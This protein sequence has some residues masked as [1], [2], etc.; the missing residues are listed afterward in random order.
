MLRSDVEDEEEVE[1][2][3]AQAAASS[4]FLASLTSEDLAFMA[5]NLSVSEFDV[6]DVIMQQGEMATWVGIVLS[7]SLV[8]Y[9]NG[10]QV[11]QMRTGC[12]VG[13]IAFFAG[14]TRLADV[15]AAEKGYL[16]SVMVSNLGSFFAEAPRTAYKL[17]RILGSSSIF[18]ITHNAALHAPLAFDLAPQEAASDV[19]AWKEDRF[20]ETLL[21][22]G[23]DAEDGHYLVSLMQ[24][25]RFVAGEQLLDA[26][27]VN[28]C[29]CFVVSGSVEVV[30][31]WTGKR[32]EVGQKDK[33][34]YDVEFFEPGALPSTIVGREDGIIGSLPY[35]V[36]ESL[37]QQKPQLALQAM[38]MVGSSALDAC[39]E[40]ARATAPSAQRKPSMTAAPENA[41]KTRRI[42]TQASLAKPSSLEVFYRNK[43]AKHSSSS[44]SKEAQSK[45]AEVA[46]E[47]NR[48][49]KS[50]RLA[51]K[52][53][54]SDLRRVEEQFA[55]SKM[56]NVEMRNAIKNLKLDVK[57]AKEEAKISSSSRG[58]K[59]SINKKSLKAAADEAMRRGSLD[60]QLGD[61]DP[62]AAAED[63]RKLEAA[64]SM[65]KELRAQNEA[66]AQ[67]VAASVTEKEKLQE[68]LDYARSEIL[69]IMQAAEDEMASLTESHENERTRLQELLELSR[70]DA[71]GQAKVSQTARR[72]LANAE[73]RAKMNAELLGEEL[74]RAEG[75]V[76]RRNHTIATQQLAA[77]G[78]GIVYVSRLYP[79]KKEIRRLGEKVAQ[80]QQQLLVIPWKVKTLEGKVAKAEAALAA[81]KQ[82][83]ASAEAERDD[84]V[85]ACDRVEAALTAKQKEFD[86]VSKRAEELE[87]WS[88]HLV[89]EL[90]KA[91]VQVR[92]LGVQLAKA[93]KHETQAHRQ[94]H[95]WA[96]RADFAADE[97]AKMAV[98]VV[99]LEHSFGALLPPTAKISKTGSRSPRPLG[100][101]MSPGRA[102]MRDGS[103][104][105]LSLRA[106]MSTPAL[107][108][109]W[110]ATRIWRPPAT[111]SASA[112]PSRPQSR[113]WTPSRTTRPTLSES[114]ELVRLGE[115]HRSG[116]RKD[117]A[118]SQAE[119]AALPMLSPTGDSGLPAANPSRHSPAVLP[120]VGA[121]WGR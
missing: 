101:D 92:H 70:K 104:S 15:R 119:V 85:S 59:S 5:Q 41:S 86:V 84:A 12:V 64:T 99:T 111:P 93:R 37:A 47:A 27:A 77:K 8:A 55:A 67:D 113:G 45:K 78:L 20:M 108:A 49:T 31:P 120:G 106:S 110:S 23:I 6:D 54:Q 24:F 7:G 33:V 21:D 65:N 22:H 97:A 95:N 29:I 76:A 38:R 11:G 42:S 109:D 96:S 73:H 102:S 115:P 112:H 90:S 66:L 25:H 13:E 74:M 17:V 52:K 53:L 57:T 79:L 94:I 3:F 40:A 36:I 82:A 88:S 81:S 87:P 91:G 118:S 62:Q 116:R 10:E 35:S 83:Q 32:Q 68:D 121:S 63:A 1:R 105:N 4:R 61:Q 100:G 39:F 48:L 9:V 117:A 72:E 107:G 75:Q 46:D 43:V 28:E 2:L 98:R 16:A 103:P 26:F 69:R 71:L 60:Q 58:R 18:Q 89:S 14:G 114:R 19:D 51:Q 50:Y 30:E 34:L 80:D 44:A 56:E